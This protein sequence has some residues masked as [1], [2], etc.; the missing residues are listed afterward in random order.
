MKNRDGITVLIYLVKNEKAAAI[1][2]DVCGWTPLAWAM[3]PPGYL[4]SVNE[5]N[6]NDPV[7]I[8]KPDDTLGRTGSFTDRYGWF[9]APRGIS[10]RS[11]GVLT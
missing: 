5:S 11:L 1:A 10:P 8:N 9:L 7:N 2:T 3:V 6:E 4:D